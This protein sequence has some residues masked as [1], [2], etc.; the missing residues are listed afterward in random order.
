MF[1]RFLRKSDQPLATV[2]AFLKASGKI[3]VKHV[4]KLIRVDMQRSGAVREQVNV[5][6]TNI[7]PKLCRPKVFS[8]FVNAVSWIATSNTQDRFS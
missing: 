1:R 5:I 6:Q 8:K 2:A 7:D 3:A 4:L